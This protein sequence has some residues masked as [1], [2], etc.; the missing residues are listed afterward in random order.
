MRNKIPEMVGIWVRRI[1]WE[2]QHTHARLCCQRPFWLVLQQPIDICRDVLSMVVDD[3][4]L[5]C[6]V[7]HVQALFF[8]HAKRPQKNH[9][10][11]R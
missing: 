4:T 6:G 1:M 5:T 3:C 10:R 11:H 8:F 7:P 2:T 9:V